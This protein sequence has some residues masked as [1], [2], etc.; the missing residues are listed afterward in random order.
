MQERTTLG[1]ILRRAL[2]GQLSG[3]WVYLPET[4]KWQ[5]NTECLFL[6][7]GETDCDDEE[8]KEKTEGFPVE[9]LDSGTIESVARGVLPFDRSPSDDLLLEAFVYYH[10]FDAFLPAPGAP[11]PPP[12]TETKRRLDK[13]FYDALGDER[14]DV[15]CKESGCERGA[16][17]FS[18]LCRRH[19]F[20]NVKR[21][22]CPFGA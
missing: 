22:P 10:R 16:I 14:S 3:G 4:T 11:D 21:E 13:E 5:P 7:D 9:G 18:T 20:E 6:G 19:H 12:W 2:D 1:S 15:R 17:R 8:L